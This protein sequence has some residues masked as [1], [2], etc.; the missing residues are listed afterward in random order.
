MR[1]AKNALHH[2]E[3]PSLTMYRMLAQPSM[4]S[5]WKIES[6]ASSN[7][8]NEVKPQF[9]AGT[10]SAARITAASAKRACPNAS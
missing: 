9:S 2:G 7:R 4:V 8:S 10:K 6:A 3:K 1:L 5:T